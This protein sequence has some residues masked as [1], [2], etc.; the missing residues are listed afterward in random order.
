MLK[1]KVALTLAWSLFAACALALAA[2]DAAAQ[3][4]ARAI[5]PNPENATLEWVGEGRLVWKTSAVVPETRARHLPSGV[6]RYYV[7]RDPSEAVSPVY[8]TTARFGTEAR[9]LGV[10]GAQGTL[11][12]ADYRQ[13]ILVPT[14]GVADPAAAA[15]VR[16]IPSDW[17]VQPADE[18]GV[19]VGL[20]LA[21][22]EEGVLAADAHGRGGYLIP[23]PPAGEAFD[24]RR[25]QLVGDV[26]GLK[27]YYTARDVTYTR[28]GDLLI[29][30]A[31][32]DLHV[33]DFQTGESARHLLEKNLIGD[34]FALDGERIVFL[35]SE[36]EGTSTVVY[37]ARTG[38][39][40][41]DGF[42]PGGPPGR[43]VHAE[44]GVAYVLE[45]EPAADANGRHAHRLSAF[46]LTRGGAR[47][48]LDLLF[49]K[50]DAR[51]GY[52][53]GFHFRGRLFFWDADV[54][55]SLPL[56][57]VEAGETL[58]AKL[59]LFRD[60]RARRESLGQQAWADPDLSAWGGRLHRLMGE[61]GELFA[62]PPYT[63][64]LLA[65]W[66]GPPDRVETF[67]Q[68]RSHLGGRQLLVEEAAN[69]LRPGREYLVYFW[70]G[71]HDFLFFVNEEGRIV[72]HGWYFAGE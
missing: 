4:E 39:R 51:R 40:L 62:R 72:S 52:F 23:W 53:P 29:W 54:W 37:E 33:F 17:Y 58:E 36:D 59:A 67:P 2:A 42:P 38:R 28:R 13:T 9:V 14:G 56:G 21:A 34:P 25:K 46:D 44:G 27:D 68:M 65:E 71:G 61:V 60:L 43:F 63:K 31:G 8:E 6:F 35:R 19:V 12:L 30:V 18:P 66:L 3:T 15:A 10:V 11:V 20:P 1:K 26:R 24:V 41:P 49:L 48:P 50:S 69:R 70:R 45:R 22:Y 64:A 16:V 7:Q 5:K 32:R 47:T 57:P 55:E